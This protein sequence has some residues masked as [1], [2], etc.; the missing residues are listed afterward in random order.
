MINY[1]NVPPR[2]ITP[3]PS[4]LTVVNQYNQPSPQLNSQK[5]ISNQYVQP[6]QIIP[7]TEI[8]RIIPSEQYQLPQQDQTQFN[9]LSL[10]E[11]KAFLEDLMQR[12]DRLAQE[13]QKA[14]QKE[15][16]LQ[17]QQ[18]IAQ[19]ELHNKLL[20]FQQEREALQQ[21]INNKNQEIHILNLQIAKLKQQHLTE[22]QELKTDNE[23]IALV[24]TDKLEQMNQF[25]KE[26]I[27]EL[28]QTKNI[29]VLREQE[30]Q[31]WRTRKNNGDI[32]SQEINQ[33]KQKIYLLQQEKEQLMDKIRYPQ[34]D[35]QQGNENQMLRAQLQEKESEINTLRLKLQYS[36]QNNNDQQLYQELEQAKEEL[37]YYKQQLMNG[38][39]VNNMEEIEDY[40]D[41]IQ[42]YE[43]EIRRLNK[44]LTEMRHELEDHKNHKSDN[45]FLRSKLSN[46]QNQIKE[47]QKSQLGFKER[48]PQYY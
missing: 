30:V 39:Q 17:N 32:Y 37:M 9:G 12:Y 2:S 26:K 21:T 33:L 10:P 22:Q 11:L 7:T 13:L 16:Q 38:G 44:Q 43:S 19:T 20:Q 47:I 1:S 6:K 8:I 5:I 41:K 25:A 36:Q 45:E 46:Q 35:Y 42:I 28:E 29:L 31:E 15:I 40:R 23:N 14:S 4:Y 18:I 34:H 24:L 3:K 27:N 48:V